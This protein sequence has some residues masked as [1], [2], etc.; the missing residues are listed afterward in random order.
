[1]TNQATK[2]HEDAVKARVSASSALIRRMNITV[3]AYERIA[4]NALMLNEDLARCS[5]DSMDKAVIESITSG[6]VPDGKEAAIVPYGNTAT[7]IPMIR[8]DLKLARRATP[9][10]AVRVRVVYHGD[11]FVHKEGLYAVLEHEV[12]PTAAQNG[13]NVIA[14]YAVAVVPGSTEPEY[15]VMYRVEL[16]RRRMMSARPNAGPWVEH[17]AE[18][19]KK[20]VL[21][22]LLKRLPKSA[23]APDVPEELENWELDVGTPP[24]PALPTARTDSAP[25]A[26]S[27]TSNGASKPKPKPKANTRT[28][29]QSRS[30]SAPPPSDEPPVGEPPEGSPF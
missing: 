21:K 10:L 28:S 1:M 6:L 22:Q 17:Y 19:C 7:L 3:E 29:T 23:D 18:Q 16:E 9:G 2:Q 13:D 8:G 15:E 12:Q 14:A 27:T 24:P 26:S 30:T 4:L 5:T 20:T 25:A 11:K